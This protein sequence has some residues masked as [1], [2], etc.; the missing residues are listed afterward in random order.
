[1]L[2]VVDHFRF[3]YGHLAVGALLYIFHTVVVVELEGLLGNLFR[4]GLKKGV[5]NRKDRGRS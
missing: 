2:Q 1:M 4:A 3:G 5:V